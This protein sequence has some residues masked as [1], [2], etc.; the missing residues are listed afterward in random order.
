MGLMGNTEGGLI[1][2]A[3]IDQWLETESQSFNPPTST[4][5]AQLVFYPQ[6][7]L[8]QDAAAIR[9]AERKLKKVLDVYDHRLSESR[10]LAGEEFSLADL[11][12]LPNAQY[13]LNS[14][15]RSHL[16]T[17][18]KNVGRWWE[19]ISGRASWKKVLEMH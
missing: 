13:L 12:H 14:T 1:H 3:S 11:S 8:K 7:K 17:S 9:D 19:E 2:R 16:F 6:M 15:D 10:F 5:V 18:K 4:L